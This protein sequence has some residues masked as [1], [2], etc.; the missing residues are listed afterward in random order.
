MQS[1]KAALQQVL[2]PVIAN[3]K[4]STENLTVPG[5]PPVSKRRFTSLGVEHVI[6]KVKTHLEADGKKELGELFETCYPN[7]LDTTV[8]HRD[9][10]QGLDTIVVTGD[11]PAMWLRDSTNQVAPYIHLARSNPPIRNLLLGLINRQA[12]CIL[13][14]VYSNAF[15]ASVHQWTPWEKDV[16]KPAVNALV[17]EGKYELDSLAAFLKLSNA[18]YA[19]TGG[20]DVTFVTE[21]WVA[22]VRVV[23]ETMRVQQ[24]GSLEEEDPAYRFV[25]FGN[26]PTD[27]LILEGRGPPAKRCGLVKSPFRP[28]DDAGT[29]PFLVPA[30]AMASIEVSKIAII[31]E[32]GNAYPDLASQAT[33][34][35]SEIKQAI[36][37]HAVFDHPRFGRIFAYEVDGFGNALFMDDANIPSLLSLPYLGFVSADDQVYQ[38]TRAFVLSNSNP[39]YFS[40]PAGSGVGSPHTGLGRIWPMA[41][42]MQAMTSS[43]KKEIEGCLDTI[44]KSAAGTGYMHESFQMNN[45]AKF[46]R[47]WFAWAN[48]L[49]GE[50]VLQITGMKIELYAATGAGKTIE[51]QVEPQAQEHKEIDRSVEMSA[52]ETLVKVGGDPS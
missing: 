50:L 39:Y 35:A 37:S 51:K 44:V 20:D 22:A 6:E 4:T 26:V 3:V 10:E 15:K 25:R 9:D 8:D 14:S 12:T 18:F 46:T 52:E 40:G 36:Y 42:I 5:R 34:L 19:A 1:F 16:V 24:K 13:S 29:Y 31:L 49:L 38:Q 32:H 23:L 41:V 48:S 11:I 2:S 21:K 28:S 17:W 7:T 27:T 45:A 30:N 43:D 33:T 47:P